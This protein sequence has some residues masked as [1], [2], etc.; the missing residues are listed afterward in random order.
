M[1]LKNP[2]VRENRL[3]QITKKMQRTVIMW[4]NLMWNLTGTRE[5]LFLTK[6]STIAISACGYFIEVFFAVRRCR[7]CLVACRARQDKPKQTD[8]EQTEST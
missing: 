8:F 1:T 6:R 7:D 2:A 4:Q 3:Q 5:N